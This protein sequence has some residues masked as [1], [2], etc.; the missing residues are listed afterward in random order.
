MLNTFLLEALKDAISAAGDGKYTEFSNAV[1]QE[2]KNK[3]ANSPEAKKFA[4][5]FDEIQRMKD[6]FAQVSNKKEPEVKQEVQKVETKE[7]EVP[8]TQPETAPQETSSEG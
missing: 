2:L 4:S 1:K 6:L 7:Q 5:D 3:L 8:E